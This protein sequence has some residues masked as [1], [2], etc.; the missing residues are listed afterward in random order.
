MLEVQASSIDHLALV[1]E[2]EDNLRAGGL[3]LLVVVEQDTPRLQESR[4]H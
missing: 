2:I 3:H 1:R 4:G